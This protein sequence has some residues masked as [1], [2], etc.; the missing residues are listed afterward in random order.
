MADEIV[1]RPDFAGGGITAEEKVQLDAHAQLWIGRVMRT[2]T[3]EPDKIIP[4]I[5][6]LYKAGGIEEEPRVVIVPSPLVAAIAGGFTAAL[7]YAEAEPDD[8][9]FKRP[10]FADAEH[11]AMR[12]A[13]RELPQDAV[14]TATFSV[15]ATMAT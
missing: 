9:P 7:L 12:D 13:L 11:L 15:A 10:K 4:A 5:I 6:D 2:K 1:R 3:I 14:R 8:S